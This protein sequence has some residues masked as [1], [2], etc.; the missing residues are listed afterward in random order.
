MNDDRREVRRARAREKDMTTLHGNMATW[1]VRRAVEI[2]KSGPQQFNT[3]ALWVA[4]ESVDSFH[5]GFGFSRR[6]VVRQSLLEAARG[7]VFCATWRFLPN[8][9]RS[10][11]CT[12]WNTEPAA[13]ATGVVPVR[14]G[15]ATSRNQ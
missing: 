7:G 15:P 13:G 3:I 6:R 14:S 4:A 12:I 8:E 2:L 10:V 1:A 5:G 9:N 11:P